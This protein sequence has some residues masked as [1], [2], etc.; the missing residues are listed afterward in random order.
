MQAALVEHPKDVGDRST[1]AVMFALQAAGYSLYVPFGENTRADLIID[2]GERLQRVQ[3][4]TGRL[5]KGCVV[6]KVCSAYAH[7]PHPAVPKRDYRGE[8]DCFA[9]YCRETG[10]VY[11]VPIEDLDIGWA[12]SLR[13]EAAK[14][15]QRRGIR[16]AARYE[17]G[18]VALRASS[19]PDASSGA[20]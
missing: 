16:N 1:L 7:H 20:E 2:D 12:A 13:V 5:R 3:C 17:V 14:N 10:G 15:N 4:K 8:V 11:L 18:A 19:G 9:V 6:F